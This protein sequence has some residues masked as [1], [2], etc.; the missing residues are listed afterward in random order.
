[1]FDFDFVF[2]LLFT[3]YFPTLIFWGGLWYRFMDMP[4]L[5][6]I[7]RSLCGMGKKV[8]SMDLVHL[9]G[10]LLVKGQHL[11]K[12][13][14]QRPPK[15]LKFE[16]NPN[17]NIKY[18]PNGKE[19]LNSAKTGETGVEPWICLNYFRF[20]GPIAKQEKK[21]GPWIWCASVVDCLL[22][23]CFIIQV[24]QKAFLKGYLER[25]CGLNWN[26]TG[27]CNGRSLAQW[28]R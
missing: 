28:Q 11:P 2:I 19:Y 13:G 7:L 17:F 25:K 23:M 6:Q 21:G 24:F 9:S 26:R 22:K 20:L 1:M 27:V 12:K 8:E 18:L 3:L 10:G 16:K 5:F 15:L 14:C 4:E